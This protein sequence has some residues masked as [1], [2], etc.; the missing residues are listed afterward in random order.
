MP[1]IAFI[2][3]SKRHEAWKEAIK[4]GSTELSWPEYRDLEEKKENK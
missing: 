4:N 2:K 1:S 3:Y